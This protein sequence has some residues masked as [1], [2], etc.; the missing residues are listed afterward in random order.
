MNSSNA[1]AAGAGHRKGDDF[2]AESRRDF[3]QSVATV[4]GLTSVASGAAEPSEK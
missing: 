1:P 4:A 2:M 3:L